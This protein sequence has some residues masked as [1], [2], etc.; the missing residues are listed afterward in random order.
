MRQ[1]TEKMKQAVLESIGVVA[2][3][4]AANRYR[5]LPASMWCLLPGAAHYMRVQLSE[6]LPLEAVTD[7]VGI[8]EGDGI[9]ILAGALASSIERG[10]LGQSGLGPGALYDMAV[11]GAVAYG[12]MWAS[13]YIFK[14]FLAKADDEV[15][16]VG[17]DSSA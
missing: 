2:A 7:T 10:S 5:G 11:G 15:A 9:V 6:K 12:G 14:N 13:H 3:M 4:G 1:S 16:D 8:N 17:G